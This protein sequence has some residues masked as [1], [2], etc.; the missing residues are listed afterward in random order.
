MVLIMN[1]FIF[2]FCPLYLSFYCSNS[3]IEGDNTSSPSHPFEVLTPLPDPSN[4]ELRSLIYNLNA[5]FGEE[6]AKEMVD[7][8]E[9]NMIKENSIQKKSEKKETASRKPRVDKTAHT[10]KLKLTQPTQL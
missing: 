1:R 8:I 2:V 4:D 10:K 5:F 6:G 9:K 3:L 7:F